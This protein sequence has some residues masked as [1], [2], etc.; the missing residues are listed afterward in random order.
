[1]RNPIITDLNRNNQSPNSMINLLAGMK[2][3]DP[4]AL[5]N[6]MMANNPKFRNFVEQNRGKTPEQI[7]I[8]NGIDINSLRNLMK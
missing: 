4:T 7:A 1:M 6:Y 2:G 3:Q 5:M 8:E